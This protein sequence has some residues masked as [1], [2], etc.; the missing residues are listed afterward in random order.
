M[1]NYFKVLFLSLFCFVLFF[2]SSI[3]DQR[4]YVWTYQFLTMDAGKGEFENYLTFSTPKAGN[5]ENNTTFENQ[6]ELEVGMTDDFD[7]SIYQVFKQ[8]PGGSFTFDSYK[9]RARYKLMK[10]DEFLFDPLI[11]AEYKGYPDFSKH[12]FEFKLIMAKD[13]GLFNVSFNPIIELESSKDWKPLFL[14]SLGMSYEFYKTLCLGV[15]FR[16]SENGHY[17]APVISHGT[18]KLWIASAPT[19]MLGGIKSGNP[20]FLFRTI[21]GVGI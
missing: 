13:I 16:G 21:I 1:Q 9:L 11:Y 8:K 2:Y 18:P 6:L 10:K 7:F 15:E 17:I 19:F 12:K 5:F 4:K 20:E 3:A 14:Y